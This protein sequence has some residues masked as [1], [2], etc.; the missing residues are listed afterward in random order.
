LYMS[1]LPHNRLSLGLKYIKNNKPYIKTIV[2]IY[3]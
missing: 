2:N 1:L 3:D